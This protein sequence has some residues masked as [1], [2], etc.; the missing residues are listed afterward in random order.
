MNLDAENLFA[1]VNQVP[2]DLKLLSIQIYGAYLPVNTTEDQ[3][4]DIVDLCA[5]N[6]DKVQAKQVFQ[7]N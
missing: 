3:K 4:R 6:K 7:I 5:F 1:F 2:E